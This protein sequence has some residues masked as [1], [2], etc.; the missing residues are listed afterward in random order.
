MKLVVKSL[1]AEDNSTS[2]PRFACCRRAIL[3]MAT[4][5]HADG[6]PIW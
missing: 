1:L 3:R 4:S 6:P 2:T 5:K